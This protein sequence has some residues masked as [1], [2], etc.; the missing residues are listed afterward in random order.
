MFAE[1]VWMHT[2]KYS[3]RTLALFQPESIDWSTKFSENVERSVGF[4]KVHLNCDGS[5]KGRCY[6]NR[7]VS[8]VGEN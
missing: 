3:I 8:R 7:F 2:Y 5:L 4:I 1:S 6:L